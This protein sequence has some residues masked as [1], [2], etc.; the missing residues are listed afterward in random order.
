MEEIVLEKEI[1]SVSS[2]ILEV[3]LKELSTNGVVR[4][5]SK[6]GG[7]WNGKQLTIPVSGVYKIEWGFYKNSVSTFYQNSKTELVLVLNNRLH[8]QKA[9]I[10]KG[11]NCPKTSNICSQKL[12]LTLNKNDRLSLHAEIFNAKSLNMKDVYLKVSKSGV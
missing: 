11:T 2:F 5:G 7:F 3:E 12:M 8:A 4:F 10:T 9:K 6:E 1:E